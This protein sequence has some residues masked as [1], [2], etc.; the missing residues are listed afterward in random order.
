MGQAGGRLR[1][2]AEGPPLTKPPA[3]LARSPSAPL[4]VRGRAQPRS[5]APA[6]SPARRSPHASG[7]GTG[8]S[9]TP[10]PREPAAQGWRSCAGPDTRSCGSPSLA[11]SPAP[12]ASAE[13]P[14]EGGF[15]A[16]SGRGGV[17]A[18]FPGV[19]RA[20]AG[21]GGRLRLARHSPGDRW[22]GN[23]GLSRTYQELNA[24]VAPDGAPPLRGV[25][26]DGGIPFPAG[27]GTGP[28]D[29]L[30]SF[31]PGS[32]HAPATPTAPGLQSSRLPPGPPRALPA[33]SPPGT[34]GRREERASD[35]RGRAR[36]KAACTP[37]RGKRRPQVPHGWPRR[38]RARRA[39]E[40]PP[41][42]RARRGGR[43]S[44]ARARQRPAGTAARPRGRGRT[45]R[46]VGRRRCPRGPGLPRAG[47]AWGGARA[48]WARAGAVRGSRAAGPRRFHFA[49]RRRREP[50]S[51]EPSAPGRA[52]GP[53][54]RPARPAPPPP[55]RL[56]P[57]L[58]PPMSD[59]DPQT[60]KRKVDPSPGG[61]GAPRPRP[62]HVWAHGFSS[63]VHYPGAPP[64]PRGLGAGAAARLTRPRGAS[65]GGAGA[66]AGARG[67]LR[68]RA[69][70]SRRAAL[71]PGF[72]GS[73][74]AGPADVPGA[75]PAMPGLPACRAGA[76]RIVPAGAARTLSC[77]PRAVVG[78]GRAGAA[79]AQP[80]CRGPRGCRAPAALARRSPDPCPAVL[81]GGGPGARSRGAGPGRSREARG[82]RRV[83]ARAAL[84]GEFVNNPRPGRPGRRRRPRRAP[85][86]RDR[87]QPRRHPMGLRAAGA[88]WPGRGP[89]A[90]RRRR[91]REVGGARRGRGRSGRASALA[92]PRRL[93]AGARG[94][95]W[96]GAR[97]PGAEGGGRARRQARPR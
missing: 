34:R 51:P 24:K 80:P 7:A 54:R 95:G 39:P 89:E 86:G 76:L 11:N 13:D 4:G 14:G 71:R 1:A 22:D 81:R 36:Q 15:G 35:L 41:G 60:E 3:L 77:G 87:A 50:R 8:R 45:R 94:R 84:G 10:G 64:G 83:R 37:G 31:F 17:P 33:L 18:F 85:I 43:K 73:C 96:A 40:A 63:R 52:A 78:A 72:R 92:L 67:G 70:P 9:S 56:S 46:A 66:L 62:A 65:E 44:R 69:G 57:A 88:G 48:D 6:P 49:P 25:L 16:P 79:R 2:P 74:R 47:G 82:A 91:R 42:P 29:L 38:G 28:R 27:C 58:G 93:A 5:H 68:S 21:V 12:A 75:L 19:P 32:L 61:R 23:L 59:S 90:R 20:P 55:R 97:A 26:G 53:R 30:V